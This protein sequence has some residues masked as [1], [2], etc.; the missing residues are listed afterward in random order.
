[1]HHVLCRT[2]NFPTMTHPK[3]LYTYF[4]TPKF[5]YITKDV[6][7]IVEHSILNVSSQKISSFYQIRIYCVKDKRSNNLDKLKILRGPRQ[8]ILKVLRLLRYRSKMT[9]LPPDPELYSSQNQNFI[10]SSQYSQYSTLHHSTAIITPLDA[11]IHFL[12]TNESLFTILVEQAAVQV[13]MQGE[14]QFY[15]LPMRMSLPAS[16][17]ADQIMKSSIKSKCSPRSLINCRLARYSSACLVQPCIGLGYTDT[18]SRLSE[19]I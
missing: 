13:V 17:L 4:I 11:I 7:T 15:E 1:M 16:Y 9:V 19:S 18:S 6:L 14:K 8:L 10:W 3:Y 5:T 12:A 2:H